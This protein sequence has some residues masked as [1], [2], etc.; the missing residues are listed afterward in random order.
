MLDTNQ[1]PFAL[2]LNNNGVFDQATRIVHKPENNGSGMSYAGRARLLQQAGELEIASGLYPVGTEFLHSVRY[3]QPMD[4][5][6]IAMSKR[7]KELRYAR[8]E[9]WYTYGELWQVAERE[10][11]ERTLNEDAVRAI[12]GDLEQGMRDQ[13][14]RYQGFIEDKYGNLR[15]QSQEENFACTGCH[16]GTGATMDTVFS[17]TRKFGHDSFQH[18]WYHW[19]QKGLVGIAEPIREDGE[20]EYTHYLQQ[21]GA[22]DE[23]RSN[24]EVMERF[25]NPDGS[26]ISAQVEALHNDITVLLFP[27]RERALN[28]NKAYRTIVEDQDF[29]RG[30]DANIT[31]VENVHQSITVRNQPSGVTNVVEG[32]GQI[33]NL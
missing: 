30:R 1:A 22:G 20:Y 7:M 8:K 24:Q 32:P 4:D 17:F 10:N 12:V 23:F 14:W 6:T 18:G 19:S 26:L 11:A 9:S 28:L 27:S 16:Y 25:F 5:G 21:N 33:S 29:N 31:P 15:P 13:G 2:D 3:L